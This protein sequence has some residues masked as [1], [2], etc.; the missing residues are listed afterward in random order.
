MKTSMEETEGEAKKGMKKQ[1]IDE[2]GRKK[3][4]SKLYRTQEQECHVWLSQNSNPRKIAATSTM[5]E[6]M[7]ETRSSKEARG[8]IDDGRCQICNQH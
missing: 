4:Q 1:R 8:L 3:Q 2:Y 5:L 6:Q 7:L